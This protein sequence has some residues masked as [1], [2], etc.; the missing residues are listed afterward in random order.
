MEKKLLAI[1]I[2]KTFFTL[3]GFPLL[4]L[5]CLIKA[6]PMFDEPIYEG[7]ATNG[8]LIVLAMWAVCEAVRLTMK[9][10]MKK[11]GTIR[12][13]IV[14]VLAVLIML[15]PMYFYDSAQEKNVAE[16]ATKTYAEK[17]V[18]K[19][20]VTVKSYNYQAGW[21]L[22]STKEHDNLI[23]DLIE[24]TD[25]CNRFYYDN[26]DGVSYRPSKSIVM[27]DD[28][29]GNAGFADATPEQIAEGKNLYY[30]DSGASIS[31]VSDDVGYKKYDPETADPKKCV[32]YIDLE[33]SEIV[34]LERNA[35]EY[36][37]DAEKLDLGNSTKPVIFVYDEDTDSYLLTSDT[38]DTSIDYYYFLPKYL[39]Y[40][41]WG[42]E[43]YM[44]KTY[45]FETI[46]ERE[47]EL[48]ESYVSAY[49]AAA[50]A[51]TSG[52][53]Y[54]NYQIAL[55]GDDSHYA[56]VDLYEIQTD[57]SY[58]PAMFPILTA[59]YFIYIFIGI[60]ALSYIVIGYFEEKEYSL[61]TGKKM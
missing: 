6:M 2:A 56:L 43:T 55:N 22:G 18:G 34:P 3:I 4:A 12:S 11:N 58:Q 53:V 23:D 30:Y 28:V 37:G 57:L 9:L 49:E 17:T 60:V 59:R 41:V 39:S 32:F 14:A 7:Y 26:L 1:K 5:L 10:C 27:E 24:L 8:I 33:E 44:G 15:L 48:L 29:R 40:D 21:V 31:S 51:P 50:V 16:L 45:G 19:S 35:K 36:P 54:D 25:D 13:I 46:L 52:T 20:T 47:I 61:K 42:Y 38:S